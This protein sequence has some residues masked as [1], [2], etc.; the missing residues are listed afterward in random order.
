MSELITFK[1]IL[2]KY[3][4]FIY[5]CILRLLAKRYKELLAIRLGKSLIDKNPRRPF[6]AFFL[7]SSLLINNR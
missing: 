7:C 6:F 5:Y 4:V 3:N 2:Q 1:N